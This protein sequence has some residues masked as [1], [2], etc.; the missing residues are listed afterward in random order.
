MVETIDMLKTCG[1]MIKHSEGK[2][3]LVVNCRNCIYGASVSDYPQCMARTFDKLVEHPDVDTINLEEFY[4]RLYN[5]KQTGVLKEVAQVLA[6][7]Q[8]ER[9]WSPSHMGGEGAEKFIAER[10][11]FMTNFVHNLLRT[12]PIAAYFSLKDEL[13]RERIRYQQGDA[14]Y[15]KGSQAYIKTLSDT[16]ALLEGTTLIRRAVSIISKLH[17]VPT[18]R[19]IYKTI[20]E[21][22]I[23]PTFIRT[24]LETGAPTGVELVDSY[25]LGESEV[26]IYKH[27]ER[28]EY[29]YYLYPPEYSL[30]PDQYFLLNKT[31][32]IVSEQKIEGVEFEDPSETRRY[33]ERIY[34]GTIAD[35]AEQNKIKLEY[36]DIQKLAKIVARYTVGFG[37]LETVL[38]DNRVTDVYIDAPIGRFPVYLVHAQYGQCETNVVFTID[39]ARSLISKFR[40]ISGRPFD[41]SHPVLDL[42][43]DVLSSRICVIGKPLSPSGISLTFRRHKE[44]PWTLSQFVDAHMINP[45]GAGLLSFFIDAQASTIVTG[46]RGSGKTSFLNALML[47]ISQNLRI[48]TQEDTLE[49]PI[50]FMKNLGFNIQQL[51]TRSAI[52]TSQTES[53]VA[54]EEAL[55]TALRL[56]DSVLI[57]GEVRSKEAKVLYEAM[58]VGAVGNV[59]MGTIHGESA[60]SVWDRIVN[61]LE[62]PTTSFKATDLVIVCAPIRFRGS[63]TKQRRV[64]QITE[65]KKHWND[66]PYVEHGFEDIMTY[67]AKND[68]WDLNKLYTDEKVY[69]ATKESELFEKIMKMRGINFNDIWNEINLRAKTKNY[70]VEMKRKYDIPMLLEST[71][72]VPI[73]NQMQL[74][75]DRNKAGSKKIDYD[76]VYSEWKKWADERHIKPMVERKAKLEEIKE[77]R[78]AQMQARQQALRMA[79]QSQQE[80]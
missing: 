32:E 62:V 52:Q 6:R 63:L 33:F 80:K 47:E 59:V 13:D 45:L 72:T 26:E 70:L 71:Y 11:D 7:L 15:Q 65:V 41:E 10:S 73:N 38:S 64:I 23:K 75:A 60:Y 20:F 53:E 25:Q 48:L 30:A 16:K 69:E 17:K 68:D 50:A 14:L 36:K 34:E 61:D 9:V 31:K 22:A 24:R 43:L 57:I 39:E 55:R 40:A 74:I 49:L 76:S 29:Q 54:P 66:D 19:A 37:L 56:G 58:R 79:K 67:S 51:K 27:P 18:G 2:K 77:Q 4:E 8:S 1:A 78:Q 3:E 5:D 12:D 28:I 46:S 21:G 35:I 44:T 42:D